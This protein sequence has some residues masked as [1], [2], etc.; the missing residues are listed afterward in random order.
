MR[1]IIGVMYRQAPGPAPIT[2]IAFNGHVTGVE[3]RTGRILWRWD[4]AAQLRCRLDF[5]ENVVFVSLQEGVACLAYLTGVLVWWVPL[6][7]YVGSLV[8]DGDELFVA[9][10]GE[11]A[12][13]DRST[14]AVLWHH[15]F[16]GMGAQPVA[17]GV[18]GNV[19]QMDG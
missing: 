19:A 5:A 14:G 16:K 13:L 3:R 2:V 6:P 11:A 18:P 17:I 1:P 8:C 9:G 15:P 4:H 12:C 7:F 10:S